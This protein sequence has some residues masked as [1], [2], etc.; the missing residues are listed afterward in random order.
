[1]RWLLQELDSVF[2]SLGGCV[3][4]GPLLLT[5]G[6]I[7]QMSDTDVNISIRKLGNRALE[8]HVFQYLAKCLQREPFDGKEIVASVC[9][10]VVYGMVCSLLSVFHEDSL[11]DSEVYFRFV[12][13]ILILLK[14]IQFNFQSIIV[15]FVVTGTIDNHA[16]K[17]LHLINKNIHAIYINIKHQLSLHVSC[18]FF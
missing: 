4:H 9:H 6:V 13:T 7:Q 3:E 18:F 17:I 5:W 14:S 8:L 15:Q 1:M 11:G 10:T 12:I 2:N 16:S